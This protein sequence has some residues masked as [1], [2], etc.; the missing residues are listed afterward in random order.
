MALSFKPILPTTVFAAYG[1]LFSELRIDVFLALKQLQI[2]L[3]EN[4]E[5]VLLFVRSV[6][7]SA[8]VS[9]KNCTKWQ[10]LHWTTR[11]LTSNLKKSA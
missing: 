6:R 1:I 9:L 7:L 11:Q 3:E 8:F 4:F 10:H 2:S 5:V